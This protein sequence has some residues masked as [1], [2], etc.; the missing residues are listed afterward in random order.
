MEETDHIEAVSDCICFGF[1]SDRNW[2]PF[3]SFKQR[4]DLTLIFK[5]SLWLLSKSRLW[6]QGKANKEAE[7]LVWRQSQ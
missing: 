7:R 1:H 6:G 4:S 2:K 5:G 3:Q